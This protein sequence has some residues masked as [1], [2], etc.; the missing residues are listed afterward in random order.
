MIT[1]EQLDMMAQAL[2]PRLDDV[3]RRWLLKGEFQ[4]YRPPQLGE[5]RYWNN[6][7]M[8]LPV[9]KDDT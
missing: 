9:M 4:L 1:D 6:R 8:M 7:Q 5:Y 2:I 3:A